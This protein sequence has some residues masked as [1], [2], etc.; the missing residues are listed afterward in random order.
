M[1]RSRLSA[2]PVNIIVIR[3]PLSLCGDRRMDA[4]RE[5]IRQVGN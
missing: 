5:S 1:G 2:H 4:V 3:K